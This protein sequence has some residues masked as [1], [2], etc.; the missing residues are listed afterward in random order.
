MYVCPVM[1]RA[2][3]QNLRISSAVFGDMSSEKL[4]H[5]SDGEIT[6]EEAPERFFSGRELTCP[7]DRSVCLDMDHLLVV[8]GLL[9]SSGRTLL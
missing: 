7:T 5:W 1:E 6:T 2:R 3:G 8:L 9:W 4:F